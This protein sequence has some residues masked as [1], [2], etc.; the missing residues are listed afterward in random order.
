M[1]GP[2]EDRAKSSEIESSLRAGR[3]SP[4]GDGG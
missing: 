3:T 2:L 4:E 1:S